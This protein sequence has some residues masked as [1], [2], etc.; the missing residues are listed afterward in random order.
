MGKR[1]PIQSQPLLQG[2][3]VPGAGVVGAP[4]VL[5]PGQ[6]RSSKTASQDSSLMGHG[7]PWIPGNMIARL[8]TFSPITTV[9]VITWKPPVYGMHGVVGGGVEPTVPP[10]VIVG[11]GVVPGELGTFSNPRAI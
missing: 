9:I 8:T 2:P 1:T 3:P 4:V 5:S 7:S 11:M 10:P 6:H